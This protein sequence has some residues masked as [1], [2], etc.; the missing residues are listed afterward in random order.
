MLHPNAVTPGPASAGPAR[1]RVWRRFCSRAPL[2]AQEPEPGPPADRRGQPI[3]SSSAT[4]TT[5]R[6][7]S[8]TAPRPPSWWTSVPSWSPPT[9]GWTARPAMWASMSTEHTDAERGTHTEYLSG[10][11]KRCQACHDTAGKAHTPEMPS[12][13]KT[14]H[15]GSAQK[16][17]TCTDCHPAHSMVRAASDG[18][19]T[20]RLCSRLPRGRVLGLRG[21]RPRRQRS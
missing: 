8:P 13:T 11:V 15:S 1:W 2:A 3:L 21:Q 10:L 16:T 4:A 17:P 6:W 14:L 5:T 20:S 12:I 9:A 19:V 18:T 7:S